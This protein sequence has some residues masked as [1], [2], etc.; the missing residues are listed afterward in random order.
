MS[1]WFKD[2]S[3]FIAYDKSLFLMIPLKSKFLLYIVCG[4]AATTNTSLIAVIY[5][6]FI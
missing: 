5:I 1:N 4:P 6:S 2:L 3:F